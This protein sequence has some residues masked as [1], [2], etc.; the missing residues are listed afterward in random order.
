MTRL[1][2]GIGEYWLDKS[3]T[4]STNAFAMARGP[5]TLAGDTCM[6]SARAYFARFAVVVVIASVSGCAFGAPTPQPV[7]TT[8]VSTATPSPTATA[9]AAVID[10][11]PRE[12]A[13]GVGEPQPDGSVLYTVEPGDVGGIIC[14]RFG[15][16]IKELQQEDGRGGMSCYTAL[17]PGDLLRLRHEEG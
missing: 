4:R 1:C 12:M 2:Q 14:E 13:T 9:P 16:D 17:M 10:G 7:P 3:A 5:K 11:G 8:S 15:L 6:N